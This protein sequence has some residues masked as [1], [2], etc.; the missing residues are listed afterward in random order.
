MFIKCRIKRNKDNVIVRI[1][2]DV[3]LSKDCQ[4]KG[5]KIV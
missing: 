4:I 5:L 2:T 3:K 1:Q